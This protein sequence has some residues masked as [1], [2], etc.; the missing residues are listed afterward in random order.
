MS[1]FIFVTGGVLSSLGKGVTSASIGSLLEGMGYKITLQK[2]DPYLNVDPGTMSPYQHGEVYVTDDGAETDLDLGHYERFTNAVMSKDN[3]VTAGKVYFNVISRERKGDY[4]G[5]TVQVIPHITEEIKSLI[6]KVAENVDVVIV[7]IGGTVGDI[8]G[9]PFLEAV[10]QLSLELGRPNYMF[11]HVTYVPFIDTAGELKTK[12]TQHSVKELRA[13]GIQPDTVICRADRDLP[14]GIRAKIA[15]FSNV[16][17]E[18]VIS[19][20][21]L[22]IIY[23]LPNH[24]KQQGL[25]R[26]VAKTLEL[27]HRDS[28]LGEWKKIVNI[29][30]NSQSSVEIAVIGKYVELKDAYK[31]ISEALTHGGIPNRLKVKIKWINSENFCVNDITSSSAILIPGGFGERGTLGKIEA[32]RIGREEGIPTFGI[33]LGMQLMAVEFARDVLGLKEANSTEF[34]EDTPYPVIDLMEDQ[35]RIEKLGGTMRLGAYPC[36]LQEK[37]KAR[38][39]YGTDLVYE[40]H[41]HRYEFNNRFRRLYEENGVRFSGLSP[42]GKLVEIMELKDHPWF[43]GCQFHPEFKSKPFNPHPL[44]VSFIKSASEKTQK[45]PA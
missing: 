10:R 8:E 29:L 44:F 45:Q 12:P 32:I 3:N 1:K 25:D 14:R 39:I 9:L 36:S 21:N 6:R 19:A 20:P 15:L 35:K 2:L 23:D 4:L 7:E 18:S 27:E 24:F 13:I 17:E 26:I 42:D 43:I 30:R 5:A 31:S 34:E 11:I 38:E 37:T 22:D 28:N 16:D 33:C 40:R 41:R